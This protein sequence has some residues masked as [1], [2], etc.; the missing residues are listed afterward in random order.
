MYIDN[1]EVCCVS[2]NQDAEIY[3]RFDHLSYAIQKEICIY[4]IMVEHTCDSYGWGYLTFAN[5]LLYVSRR[6]TDDSVLIFF[7][8]K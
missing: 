8:I 6:H 5:Y 1:G 7:P 3:F 4:K 2:E